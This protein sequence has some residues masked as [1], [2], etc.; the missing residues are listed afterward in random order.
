MS[1]ITMPVRRRT[2]I[3]AGIALG[4]SQVFGGPFIVAARGDDEWAAKNLTGT[5]RNARLDKSAAPYRHC[6]L[7]H[8]ELS[9]VDPSCVVC[10]RQAGVNFN[11]FPLSNA[12]GSNPKHALRRIS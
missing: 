3:Q 6:D 2:F 11:S 8:F 5:E 7:R 4:A 9:F 12:A 10:S 1:K